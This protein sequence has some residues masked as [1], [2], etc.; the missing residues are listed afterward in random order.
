MIGRGVQA[1]GAVPFS[2][3]SQKPQC[4][5]RFYEASLNPFA[6][7]ALAA[8]PEMHLLELPH[9]ARDGDLGRQPLDAGGAEE[10]DDTLGMGENVLSVLGLGDR[11]A[12]AE[13][14]DTRIDRLGGIAQCL[15][16]SGRLVERQRRAG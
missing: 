11:S 15:H 8:L 9:T 13:D 6:T 12:M 14:E 3:A 16:T 10:A 7:R 5:R 2:D 1:G 4:V